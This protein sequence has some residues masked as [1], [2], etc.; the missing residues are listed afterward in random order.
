M[1]QANR[2][3]LVFVN[4]GEVYFGNSAQN[5]K[6]ILGSCVAI[7]LW[8]PRKKLTGLCHYVMPQTG[9]TSDGNASDGSVS[10][11]YAKGAIQLLMDNTRKYHTDI[12]EYQVSLYGGGCLF[13][14]KTRKYVDIGGKNIAVAQQWVKQLSIKPVRQNVGGRCYRTITVCGLTGEVTLFESSTDP[15][16]TS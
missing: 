11:R 16:Q 1:S 3:T 14:T 4:P 5:I 2:D 10:G 7:V 15:E 12:R 8:H 6:T 13:C 9:N